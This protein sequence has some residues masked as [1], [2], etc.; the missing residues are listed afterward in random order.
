M[1]LEGLCRWNLG[2]VINNNNPVKLY[3]FLCM[4]NMYVEVDLVIEFLFWI[5]KDN[6]FASL[7]FGK[8]FFRFGNLYT[9]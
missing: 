2:G 6:C 4:Y 3:L 1:H 5:E 8:C 7:I 9:T